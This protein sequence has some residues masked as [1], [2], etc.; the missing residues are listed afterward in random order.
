M[1]P[2]EWIQRCVAHALTLEAAAQL[3]PSDLDEIAKNLLT[4]RNVINLQP[5]VAADVYFA[6]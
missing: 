4:S 5:E 3:D 2:T 6:T 1:S